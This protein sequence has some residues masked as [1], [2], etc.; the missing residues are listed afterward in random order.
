MTGALLLL[1]GLALFTSATLSAAESAAYSVG[2]SRVRTL[3]EE[4]FR[5]AE[6][7]SR[8]RR[9]HVAIRSTVLVVNSVLDFASVG[10]LV[11]GATLQWGTLAIPIAIPLSA[12][13]VLLVSGGVPRLIA[14]RQSLRLA[15]VS[16]PFLIALER[17][18]RPFLVPLTRLEEIVTQLKEEENGAASERELR[19]L[20]ELG[21]REG[22]V[23]EEEH[24][25]VER[26]SGWTSCR[27]GTS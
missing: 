12:L 9:D 17:W 1:V 6:R 10:M 7:L 13:G 20:T 25:L 14:T 8:V 23:E 11:A 26:R 3:V 15:L 16:A 27:P 2:A 19:E 22:V 18:V 24:E 4:G 5:G 21:R